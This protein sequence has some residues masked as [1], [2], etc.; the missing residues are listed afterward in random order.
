MPKLTDLDL[1]TIRT[2]RARLERPFTVRS[3]T[4]SL[5]IIEG[6]FKSLDSAI[7]FADKLAAGT[8]KT[9][10]GG[11]ADGATVTQGTGGKDGRGT[12]LYRTKKRS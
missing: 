6:N 5:R 1:T 4:G 11:R 9:A 7:Q 3:K 10:V 12:V 8:V 2:L